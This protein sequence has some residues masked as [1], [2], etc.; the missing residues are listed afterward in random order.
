MNNHVKRK[1][2]YM[3]EQLTEFYKAQIMPGIRDQ[4]QMSGRGDVKDTE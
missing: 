2:V 1:A 4:I 3:W